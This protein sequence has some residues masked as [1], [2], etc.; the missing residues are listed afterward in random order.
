MSEQQE[1]YQ[2][3]KTT[4]TSQPNALMVFD[5]E[6]AN[7]L[8]RLAKTM[9]ESNLVP[10]DFQGKPSDCFLA[11]EMAQRLRVA[12][13]MVLQNLYVVH[14]RPGWSSQFLIAMANR[15][16][17]FKGTIMFEEFGSDDDLEVAA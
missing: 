3:E 5:K 9:S 13:F 2:V 6:G 8:Y 1:Q 15:S 4:T 12:P 7:H 11:V 10:K 16:G 14:G 17:T